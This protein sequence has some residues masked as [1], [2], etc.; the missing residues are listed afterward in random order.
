MREEKKRKEKKRK[1]QEKP[2]SCGDE[3]TSLNIY[4]LAGGGPSPRVDPMVMIL[5]I[6][7][8]L[9][10]RC[11]LRGKLMGK[12]RGDLCPLRPFFCLFMGDE[13]GEKGI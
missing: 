12:L 13:E 9:N 1:R 3:R 6:P 2:L 8:F 10:L 4:S 11:N 5:V 7:R